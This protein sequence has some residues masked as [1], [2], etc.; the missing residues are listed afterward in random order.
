MNLINTIRFV[1]VLLAVILFFSSIGSALH[2]K[3]RVVARPAQRLPAPGAFSTVEITTSNS[4]RVL[5]IIGVTV[6]AALAS[7]VA[8]T[9]VPRKPGN[10]HG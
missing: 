8:W 4:S 10:S 9:F 1:A 7:W 5:G 6:G 3:Y 2:P